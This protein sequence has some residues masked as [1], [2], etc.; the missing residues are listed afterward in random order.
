MSGVAGKGSLQ[1]CGDDEFL[2]GQ[3]EADVQDVGLATDLAVFDVRLATARGLVDDGFVPF[4][5]SG[6]LEAGIHG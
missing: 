3:V 6:A 1:F 2:R 5:A 4:P